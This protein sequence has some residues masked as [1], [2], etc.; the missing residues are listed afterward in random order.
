[1][2][3]RALLCFLQTAVLTLFSVTSF[4][5]EHSPPGTGADRPKIA[6]VLGGGGA[7]AVAHLGVLKELERQRI[8]IDLIVGNGTG[9]LVGGLYA[10][11][12][13][14]EQISNLL[15]N[16]DWIEIFNPDTQREDMSFRRKQDD[17]DFLIKYKVG[18]KDG[19]AQLP[20][21]LNPNGKLGWLLQS[22]TANT[23]GTENFDQLPV[24]FRAMAMDLVTGELLALDSGA[25]SAAILAT[26]AA[27]GTLPP[28][29][30]G[31]RV[32]VTGG[33]INNLPVNVAHDWGADI[34]IVV[35][36]GVFTSSADQLNSV[37]AIVDQVAHLLQRDSSRRGIERM[38]ETDILIMPEVGPYA[39]TDFTELDERIEAGQAATAQFASHLAPLSLVERDY[40]AYV[41]ARAAREIGEPII[42]N[43]MLDNQSEVSDEVI[44]AQITQPIDAPLDKPRLEDD[45]RQVYALGAFKAVEFNILEEQDGSVL[46]I[47]TIE[48][49]TSARFWRFGIALEDDFDGNSAYTGS[50]SFTWT[51]INRLNAEWRS[52]IRIGEQQQLTTEFFQP[53]V[54]SG[55]WY[56]SARGGFVERNVNTFNSD[57][58]IENQ[59]RVSSLAAGLAA[60]RFIGNVAQLEAGL[61]TGQG[62][63][64]LNIGDPSIGD[65]EFDIGGFFLRATHDSLDNLY[66]PKRGASAGLAWNGQ[67]ETLGASFDVDLVLGNFNAAKTWGAHSL[68]GGIDF[69]TQVDEVAGVQN[70]LRTGGLFS[71]SG[72][73]RDALSGKHT[74]I[75][76]G[77]YYRELRSNPVR[78]FLEATIYV[79]GSLELGNAWQ[80][81]D[82]ISL[83]NT[84]LAGSLFVGMDTFIGPVYFAGG[85]SEGGQ[86]ALYLFVGRPF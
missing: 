26:V 31:D 18:I 59:F 3:T 51:Q 86:S 61:E 32:L 73:P 58:D 2:S 82:D 12:K 55:K 4:A 66:F 56:V 15:S 72:Y 24:A 43:V 7:H 71:L 48:D 54:A 60:G 35:D 75:V 50:A 14:V 21:A 80:D 78:G 22:E 42:L 53:V 10:S 85:L 20:T 17:G 11:G 47:T 41:A 1:M 25:L 36:V 44:R 29:T 52:V 46:K 70:L 5:S 33:L 81:S 74:G 6:L 9:G 8:P 76:R 23:K 39:E 19:E 62:D 79:G 67:R 69:Q 49:K 38:R 28:V 84:L 77:I 68:L 57:G 30:I 13:S 40:D 16:T 65:Q 34:V 64:Q 27:P 45:L 37:F 83:S 63:T